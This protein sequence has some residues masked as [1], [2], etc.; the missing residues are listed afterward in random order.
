MKIDPCPFCGGKSVLTIKHDPCGDQ[1][2]M[3]GVK[4]TKCGAA[5]PQIPCSTWTKGIGTVYHNEMSE[6]EVIERWNWRAAVK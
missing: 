6:R 4:C 5:I 3:A 1:T 2:R